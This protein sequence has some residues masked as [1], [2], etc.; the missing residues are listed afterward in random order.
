MLYYHVALVLTKGKGKMDIYLAVCLLLMAATYIAVPEGRYKKTYF[1]MV[2]LAGL[3]RIILVFWLYRN[4]TDTF[5]T[6]GLLYHQEGIKIANML[7]KGIPF[8]Q[9]KYSYTWYTAF[10][11]FVYHIT[12]VNRYVVSYIN[13]IITLYA[14]IM[15][16]RMALNHG[17]SFGNAA[18]ISLCF[19]YF[20]NLIL[21]TADSRKEALLIFLSIACWYCFQHFLR[22]VE[23]K[24]RRIILNIVRMAVICFFIW[25][26]TLVRIYMFIPLGAGII[27]SLILQYKKNRSALCL[28]FIFSV[29][30]SSIVML[31]VTVNPLTEDYHAVSF[32]QEPAGSI[33]NELH[34]KLTTLKAIASSRN[35]VLS[36]INSLILPYPGLIDIADIRGN[37]SMELIVSVDMIGWYFCLIMM[38]SGIYYS[39]KKQNCLFLGLLAYTCAYIVI[40][41]MV[42]ENVSDTIYRYRSVIVGTSL[43]FINTDV[44]KKLLSRFWNITGSKPGIIK[45]KTVSFSIKN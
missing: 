14:A 19:L 21:W 26:C 28:I 39:L 22:D 23:N 43:L 1:K 13:I 18:F 38:A 8:Y 36:I 32:P 25:L 41:A 44:L 30:A 45:A 40:N 34:M 9:V 24:D 6:D 27:L 20:P 16:L 15:L 12:G 37:Y 2:F 5:G 4:G 11:G 33:T 7:A 10:I 31:F 35:I 29:L 42:V 3:L 17:Y